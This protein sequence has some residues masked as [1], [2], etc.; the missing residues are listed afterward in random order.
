MLDNTFFKT[1]A[2]P[3]A[4]FT[5]QVHNC[6]VERQ[7][8]SNSLRLAD[9]LLCLTYKVLYVEW[10]KSNEAA[11]KMSL[12]RALIDVCS[13]VQIANNDTKEVKIKT[14]IYSCG[15]RKKKP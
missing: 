11:V 15:H 9:P 6:Y 1:S 7:S 12:H 3:D 8:F 13:S 2:I 14:E 10:G 5:E 4:F